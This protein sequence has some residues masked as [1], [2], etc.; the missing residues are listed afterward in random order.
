MKS[1]KITIIGI[2]LIVAI[3]TALIISSIGAS[4]RE[5]TSRSEH[6][7]Y[8]DRTRHNES[9]PKTDL[10]SF[11]SVPCGNPSRCIFSYCSLSWSE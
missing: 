2:L 7:T 6:N 5:S 1:Q 9:Y 4:N 10:V 8:C 11:L 3:V